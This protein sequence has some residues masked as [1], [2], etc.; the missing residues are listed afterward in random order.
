MKKGIFHIH[1]SFSYDGL[2]SIRGIYDFI[3][4]RGLNFIILSDHD[5]IN[6][7]LELKKFVLSRGL[8]IEVPISAEYKTNWGDII[9]VNIRSEIN[10]RDPLLLIDEIK[11]QG[12]VSILPHPYDGHNQ[13]DILAQRVDV[14]E[15]YNARSSYIN[16]LK[17]YSLALKYSKPMIWSSDSHI[18]STLGN[19]IIG[20]SDDIHFIDA[21]VS[22]KLCPLSIR[23]SGAH[24]LLF[25]QLKKSIVKKDLMIVPFLF[26][27]YIKSILQNR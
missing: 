21:M 27:A 9:A 5:T 2:N 25:S 3:K 10:I 8:N 24:D 6:G 14:I 13:I 11:M 12:G 26:L 22:G 23:K 16:N 17:S 7:S 15:V 19:A 1:S 18:K 4:K 20:Y